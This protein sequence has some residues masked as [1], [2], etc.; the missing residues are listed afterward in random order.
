MTATRCPRRGAPRLL[1]AWPLLA[2]WRPVLALAGLLAGL[3]LPTPTPAR[4]HALL[5]RSDPAS[6]AAAAADQPPGRIALWYSEPVDV[7]FNAVAVLDTQNRRVD[8][9]DA[10]VAPEDPTRVEVSLGRLS[11]GGYLVRWQVTSTDNHVVRGTFWFAVGVAATPPAASLFGSDAPV[12]PPLEVVAR[13]LG[14]V[15]ILVLAG[16]PFF[17]LLVLGSATLPAPSA[18]TGALRTSPVWLTAGTLLVLAQLVWAAAQA[19]AVADLP[20][21]A[22]PDPTILAVVLFGSRFAILWWSRLVLGLLLAGLLLAPGRGRGW[23]WLEA[24]FGVL[25]LA[26]FSLG[27]HAAGARAVPPVAVAVDVVH[28]LAAA[29]WLGGLVHL[30]LVLSAIPLAGSDQRLAPLRRLVP[31]FSAVALASVAVLGASGLF[32]AWEQVATPEALAATAY[33]QTLLLKL[34][35]LVPLLGIAAVNLLVVRPRFAAGHDAAAAHLVPT[36]RGL[37]LAET[38]VG[39]GLLLVVALLTSFQ[40]PGPQSLPAPA[41]ATRSAGD[42]RVSLRVDPNWAGVSKFQVT[43]ADAQGQPPTDV[44]SVV[45]T[46]TMAGMNMGRTTVVAQPVG[47]GTYE[48]E[49]YYVG[50][51]G[52]SQVGIAVGRSGAADQNPL[53]QIEVPDVK[54][55]QFLGL[56]A[57]LGVSLTGWLGLALALVVGIGLVGLGQQRAGRRAFVAQGLAALLMLLGAGVFAADR[58]LAN[59]ASLELRGASEAMTPARLD[60]GQALYAESCVVCHGATGVG[61]GPA[62]A[63]LLPP[64]ADLTVHTRWHADEQLYWFI[65]HGV[66]GT[67]ML[68]F[69]DRLSPEE[70]WDVIGYL[71]QLASAPTAT[72]LA[73]LA[74]SAPASPTF[75]PGGPAIAGAAA[76][77]S[78][79]GR[80]VYGPDTEK[81]FL[82][83][84][85]PETRAEPLMTFGPLE[86]ASS[87]A[88]SP[89]GAR[90]AFAYYRL[91][92]SDNP[93]PPGTD[94]YVM[95]ADGS[96]MRMVAG[97]DVSGAALQNPAWSSDG[98]AIYVSYQGRQRSGALVQSVDRVELAAGTRTRIVSDAAY[99]SLSRDGQHLAYV[100]LPGSGQRGSSLWVGAPDGGSPRQLLGPDVFSR[101]ANVRFAPDSRRLVFAA[102]GQG[103][104]YQPPGGALPVLGPAA[105]PARQVLGLLG[106]LFEV[107]VARA[108][109]TDPWEVWTIAIDGRDLRRLTNLYEDLPVAS[110]SPDGQSIAFLGGGSATTGQTGLAIIGA[111][112]QGLRRLAP[113]PGHRG[114]D[115]APAAP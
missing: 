85:F 99:P 31:R 62:A 24:L 52:L 57:S 14:L 81:N 110:W 66:A 115:W 58:S 60:R 35:V 38:A 95:N 68:R 27:S 97:H 114:V 113:Q 32:S 63:S 105:G 56:G 89:D 79:V 47:A 96:G 25:L 75:S 8:R 22:L 6:G 103:T 11:E 112:G 109:G 71:H 7:A 17:R 77:D 20:V 61:N 34:A 65:T 92:S 72:P 5:L 41:E 102:V 54:Q 82:V 21:L 26:T 91:R 101:L 69:G 50:M 76:Q 107:P 59:S 87:P 16:A 2:W 55:S 78:L 53:F 90:I 10:H 93:I 43:L 74:A 12:A 45:L 19:Q 18:A 88:W 23:L 86:F 44:R 98:S 70:R 83:W 48:A 100:R 3:L 37:V 13:W 64:P 49:G 67:A 28:L 39:G 46:F 80:L 4:A 106:Q 94:L 84:R 108:N 42:L 104:N 29:V 36:F 51:P 111:E 15:A 40:P 33:G 9:L 30:G 73:S 1:R